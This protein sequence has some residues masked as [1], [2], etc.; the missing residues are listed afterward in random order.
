MR[1]DKTSVASYPRVVPPR[2]TPLL[3]VVFLVACSSTPPPRA[4]APPRPPR[5]APL[6]PLPPP[7][8][9]AALGSALRVVVKAAAEMPCP[10]LGT[11]PEFAAQ[12]DCAAMKRFEDAVA[13]VPRQVAGPLPPHVDLRAHGLSG[14]V[15][16][17]QQVGACAGFAMTTVLDNFA[18][19]QGRR[20]DMASLHVFSIYNL[21]DEVAFSRALRARPVTTEVVWPYDPV[22]A[23]RF[24]DDWT[25]QGC[26]GVYGVPH[27][28]ARHDPHLMGRK[29]DADRRG[30][31]Q[32][33]GYEELST[34]PVDTDQIAMVLA[35]GEALW[36]ALAF[37][38]PAWSALNRN[39][40]SVLPYFPPELQELSHAVTLEGYR[41]TPRGRQFL[42]HNS[43]GTTWGEGGYAWIDEAM[44]RTHLN[45]AY[46]VLVADAS[47]PVPR[48]AEQCSH[49]RIPFLDTCAPPPLP[50]PHLPAIP[51]LPGL[52]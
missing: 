3:T 49:G 6:Q 18:R 12:I 1:R 38:R 48:P 25:G 4:P 34:A 13:Y 36:A 27:D 47:L 9:G 16:D 26:A 52:P 50:R 21:D 40:G 42:L 11:P 19:R 29:V 51:W 45:T 8:P 41:T 24:A 44:L 30:R 32:I 31:W 14:P 10:P 37:H 17:Q 28:S 43:W 35:S 23:C 20:D 33:L 5:S 22:I 46:R 2:L 15:R 39:R 7:S